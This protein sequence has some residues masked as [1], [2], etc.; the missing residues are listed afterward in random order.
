V[1]MGVAVTGSGGDIEIH[2]RRWLRRF[3]GCGSVVHGHSRPE[4]GE[5]EAVPIWL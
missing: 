2:R 3:G 4:D 5:P 1:D